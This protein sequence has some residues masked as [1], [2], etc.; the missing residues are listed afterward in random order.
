MIVHDQDKGCD[1]D[2]FMP[3][4]RRVTI[5]EVAKEAGVSAQTVSRVINNRHDVASE[6]RQR[7]LD[8]ITSLGYQPSYIA[9]SLIHGNSCTIGVVAYGLKF[10][11]P[12]RTFLGIEEEAN[13]KGYDLFLRLIHEPENDNGE[14]LVK[15]MLS[16]QVE[17]IIW[18]V[19]QIASN[20]DWILEASIHLP[21]PLVLLSMQEHPSHCVVAIDNQ[22]G[23]RL[24]T[25][26]LIQ[27]GYRRIGIITGPLS[28]WEAVQRRMGWE[29]A[30]SEAGIH[31][32]DSLIVEG[33]WTPISGEQSLHRLLKQAP[34]IDAV[35]VSNDQMAI[36]AMK[37]A[38]E[39][40]R[41]IPKDLG[42]IGFDNIS[43]SAYFYPPL[44]TIRQ[45]MRELGRRAVRELIRIVDG[46][47]DGKAVTPT[48]TY[49]Q[50][51]LIVRESS[52]PYDKE[53]LQKRIDGGF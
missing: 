6:T 16:H 35:F 3:N 36:G 17:G 10:Y 19:P 40:G 8:I 33:D 50:P 31:V 45:D 30:L 5:K 18:A 52:V 11:G 24:A 46:L 39:L 1:L 15:S 26:H 29:K 20:R 2:F 28:W 23:G 21:V 25:Q 14:E 22:S 51:E 41:N 44:S 7:I 49:I 9:R 12:S 27:Q 13:D 38:R 37:A 4:P 47:D 43:E 53:H 48:N 42:I 32:K 34:E